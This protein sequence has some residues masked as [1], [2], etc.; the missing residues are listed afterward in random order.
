MAWCLINYAQE[1]F[2]Y[3][4]D[5]EGIVSVNSETRCKVLNS[6]RIHPRLFP[7]AELTRDFAQPPSLPSYCG[8]VRPVLCNISRKVILRDDIYIRMYYFRIIEQIN[9]PVRVSCGDF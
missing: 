6:D 2:Y 1:R 8:I 5:A 7:K 3:Y 4:L 9:C